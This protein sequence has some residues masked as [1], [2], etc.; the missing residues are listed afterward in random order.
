MPVAF[1][2]TVNKMKAACTVLPEN[3]PFSHKF[4]L[5]VG[6][7]Y[8]MENVWYGVDVT[9]RAHGGGVLSLRERGRNVDHFRGPENLIHPECEHSGHADRLRMGWDWSKLKET[10]M[11]CAGIRRDGLTTRLTLDGVVDEGQGLRTSVTFML[12]DALPLLVWER[13]FQCHKGKEPDKK[14]DKDEKPKELIDDMKTVQLGFRAAWQPE[15]KGHSGSRIL[16]ADGDRLAVTR[17]VQMDQQVRNRH[18]RMLDGWTLVEHPERGDD[19]LYLFDRHR[20]PHLFTWLG[21]HALTLEP[22]WPHMPVRPNEVV[23][24][25][26][27]LTAGEIAGASTEGAWVAS[28]AA[29]PGGGV[30]ARWSPA[31]GMPS[32]PP[33][34]P[35]LWAGRRSPRRCRVSSCPA[36]GRPASPP[37]TSRRA[38]STSRSPSMWTVSQGGDAVSDLF[39]PR[40]LEHRLGGDRCQ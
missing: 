13:T 7:Q 39:N 38:G 2:V 15:R 34:L 36:S 23:G 19:P 3:E 27:A 11:T 28:R 9:G 30:P 4:L 16:C 25:T 31:C 22:Q 8:R 37:P 18:W 29:L 26:L 10:S 24:F 14:D 12:Y 33:P 35:S 1:E 17:P 20:P 21:E 40:A 5:P 6:E 32:H